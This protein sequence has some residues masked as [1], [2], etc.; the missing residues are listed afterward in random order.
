MALFEFDEGRLIPA[1]FGHP[2]DTEIDPQILESV[3]TQ[4][5][6]VIARPLFPVTWQDAP[7]PGADH[8]VQRLTA[9]DPTGQVV[10]VEVLEKLDSAG[11][12]RALGKLSEVARMGWLELAAV[13]PGGPEAFR[14]AWAKFRE[15]MPASS[16]GGSRMILVAAQIDD[17]VRAVVDVL[18]LSG[19]EVFEISVR[20]MANGRRFID[21]QPVSNH[22]FTALHSALSAAGADGS[23]Q[24]PGAG[25][26]DFSTVTD[27]PEEEVPEAETTA[28]N[29]FDFGEPEE[30]HSGAFADPDSY[31]YWEDEATQLPPSSI[32]AVPQAEP[33]I[34]QAEPAVPEAEPVVSA[35][36]TY[37]EE[38]Q[39]F[40]QPEPE[41][42]FVVPEESYDADDFEDEIHD[43][44]SGEDLEEEPVENASEPGPEDDAEPLYL[45]K[46]DAQGLQ[47][48]A[49]VLGQ[50]TVLLAPRPDYGLAEAMLDENG[51]INCVDGT[52]T[53][54]VAYSLTISGMEVEG[55][56]WNQ[57][58]I[59]LADG[60]TLAEAADEVNAELERRG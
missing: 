12:I 45:V 4:V 14:T 44:D 25:A 1:Q 33:V 53:E 58:R 47:T 2:V 3:R 24:L 50:R 35:Q 5:L 49:A 26:G 31:G 29:V 60:P 38:F 55:D 57:W 10:A 15:A 7:Q 23:F 6:E 21:V 19:L 48:L 42:N 40:A 8:G 37:D 28:E 52:T 16:E 34:P 17:S 46:H 27:L 11:L 18:V 39:A 41:A 43:F 56:G 32:P 54:D 13:Y 36:I 59:G 20:Q 51:I 9:I 22:S 30:P